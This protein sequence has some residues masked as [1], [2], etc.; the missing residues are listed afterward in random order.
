MGTNIDSRD[1]LQQ[2]HIEPATKHGVT[3]IPGTPYIQ[4]C[5]KRRHPFLPVTTHTHPWSHD[6]ALMVE[7]RSDGVSMRMNK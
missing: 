7:S 3:Y 2:I 1:H 5:S 6:A 4:L